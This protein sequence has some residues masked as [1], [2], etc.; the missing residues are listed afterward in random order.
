VR[1]IFFLTEKKILRENNG[2]TI[3]QYIIMPALTY[4]CACKRGFAYECVFVVCVSAHCL[5][6]RLK[7]FF[8]EKN[9]HCENNGG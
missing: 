3:N 7:F 9:I 4:V 5:S 2:G 6:V 8:A 1:L